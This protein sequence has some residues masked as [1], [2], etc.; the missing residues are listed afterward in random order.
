MSSDSRKKHLWSWNVTVRSYLYAGAFL[1]NEDEMTLSFET[2]TEDGE[3][4]ISLS[5]FTP[6]KFASA[7]VQQRLMRRGAT[8]WKCRDKQL[9][10]YEG[11]HNNE[12][13][14][15][16]FIYL[17]AQEMPNKSTGAEIH[18]RFFNTYKELHPQNSYSRSSLATSK[19]A[20]KLPKDGGEPEAP[21]IY[22]FPPLVPGFDLWRKKWI[23]PEVGQ[24]RDVTWNEHAFRSLEADEDMKELILAL[25]TNQLAP[26]VGTD[27]I[28]KKGNGLIM[29]LHGPPGTGKTFMAESVAEIAKK[30][31]Y[32]VTCGDFGTE[33]EAVEKYLEAVEKYLESVFHL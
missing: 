33:P 14:A 10:A 7:E 11:K 17:T 1:N 12:N 25:V 18:D 19:T 3:V 16:R 20:A 30:P 27:L 29:P 6:L 13:Q 5:N 4:D 26:E 21:E 23:D 9:V 2:E 24:I 22:L 31:L 28:D 32:S 15:V 8:F